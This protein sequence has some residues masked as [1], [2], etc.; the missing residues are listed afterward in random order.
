MKQIFSTLFFLFIMSSNFAQTPQTPQPPVVE[1]KS[2]KK[3]GY[4]EAETKKSFAFSCYFERKNE[5]KIHD[6]IQAEYPEFNKVISLK[7]KEYEILIELKNKE[8]KL[9]FKSLNGEVNSHFDKLKNIANKI[10][11][12]F[13]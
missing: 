7:T 10:K 3:F 11:S 6:L 2:S 5:K 9:E 1:A 12:N 4:S 8:L 13:S